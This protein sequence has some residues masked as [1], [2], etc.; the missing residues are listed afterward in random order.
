MHQ[1]NIADQAAHSASNNKPESTFASPRRKRTRRAQSLVEFALVFPFLMFL[2]GGLADFGHALQCYISITN[3]ASEGGRIA[4]RQP[5]NTA[6]IQ[7]R[8]RNEL[9]GTGITISSITVTYPN[10]DSTSGNPVRVE[11]VCTVP[12]VLG[13]FTGYDSIRVL[14]TIEMLIL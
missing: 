5:T 11:V 1:Q 6:A 3:A 10:G 2:L 9:Y 12:T 8:V 4:A 13:S 7:Q 14:K